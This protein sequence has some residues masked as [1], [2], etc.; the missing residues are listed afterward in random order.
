MDPL[1]FCFWLQGYLELS[2][3]DNP[4]VLTAHQVKMVQEHLAMVF[5]SPDA[6][7]SAGSI[8]PATRIC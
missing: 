6:V 3:V 2:G 7:D 4:D 1:N 8:T 5:N